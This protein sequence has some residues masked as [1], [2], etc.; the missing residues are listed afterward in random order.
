M[1]ML[2]ALRRCKTEGVKVRPVCWRTHWR[3]KKC[4]VVHRTSGPHGYFRLGDPVMVYP[5]DLALHEEEEFL[6]EWEEVG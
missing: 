3:L 5:Q 1:D 4:C 6:G 2:T